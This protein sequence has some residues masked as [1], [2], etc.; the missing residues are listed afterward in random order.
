MVTSFGIGRAEKRFVNEGEKNNREG[1]IDY[2]VGVM[3][4]HLLYSKM[5]YWV[6][7]PST[8]PE[9]GFLASVKKRISIQSPSQ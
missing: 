6:E 5:G 1:K 4:N 9:R 8:L 7:I 2:K 3:H